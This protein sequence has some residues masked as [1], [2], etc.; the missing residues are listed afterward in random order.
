MAA[1]FGFCQP[2]TPK[3]ENRPYGYNEEKWHWSYMPLSK[4]FTQQAGLHL[5]D[6]MIKGFEGAETAVDIQVIKHFVL[7]INSACKK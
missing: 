3:G 4:T 5:K 2:Y 6:K 7:G 1:R